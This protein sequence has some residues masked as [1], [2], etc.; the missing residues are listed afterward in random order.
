PY[1]DVRLKLVADLERRVGK[2][3]GLSEAMALDADMVRLLWA[4]VLLNIHR[5]NR[6]KPLVVAQ[7]VRRLRWDPYSAASLLPIL[8]VAVRSIRGPE[9]RAGL[10]GVVQLVEQN[11]NLQPLVREAFPE[12]QWAV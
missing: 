8:S 5:G 6:A 1:D 10:A 12:L 3:G 9:W 2:D 4:S 7:M 11:P